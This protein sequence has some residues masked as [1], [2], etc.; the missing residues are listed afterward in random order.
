LL[1]TRRKDRGGFLS[2]KKDEGPPL[3]ELSEALRASIEKKCNRPFFDVLGEINRP[4]LNSV[5]TQ[6]L[7][8]ENKN[9]DFAGVI[10]HLV[11]QPG[12]EPGIQP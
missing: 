10:R 4:C 2:P 6:I 3:K 11:T 7:P 9:T 12:I 1:T 5:S 8:K